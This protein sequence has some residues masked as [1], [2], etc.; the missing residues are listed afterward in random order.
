MFAT[1]ISPLPQSRI[2]DGVT[3]RSSSPAAAVMILNVDPGSYA[4]CTLR[5]FHAAGGKSPK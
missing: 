5:F 1:V 3:M 4:S 2:C